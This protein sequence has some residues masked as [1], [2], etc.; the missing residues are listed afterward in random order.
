MNNKKVKKLRKEYK[1]SLIPSDKEMIEDMMTNGGYIYKINNFNKNEF[2]K[3]KKAANYTAPK[4]K[5]DKNK[6][7]RSEVKR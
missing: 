7:G 6:R 2:R 3:I 4:S 5:S 1:E